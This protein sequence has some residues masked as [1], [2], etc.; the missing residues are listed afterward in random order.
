MD[1][2][3]TMFTAA[4]RHA[5]RAFH[6]CERERDRWNQ[7]WPVGQPVWVRLIGAGVRSWTTGPAEV[8]GNQVL[9]PVLGFGF[10]AVEHL[11]PAKARP[12]DKD[13]IP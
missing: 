4:Q 7:G 5:E 6:R 13:R 2:T 10:Y 8:R 12:E 11:A 3:G 9:V 1:G